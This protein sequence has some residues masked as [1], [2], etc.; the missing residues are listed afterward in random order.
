MVFRSID[1][2]TAMHTGPNTQPLDIK[3]KGCS[4]GMNEISAAS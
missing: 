4:N 1:E 2:V 3:P